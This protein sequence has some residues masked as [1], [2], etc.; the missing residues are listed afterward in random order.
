MPTAGLAVSPQRPRVQIRKKMKEHMIQHVALQ[1]KE[2]K[3]IFGE[4]AS[5]NDMIYGLK[6]W[7]HYQKNRSGM[8]KNK[9][10]NKVRESNG[11]SPQ[12]S[13]RRLG[14]KEVQHARST[15]TASVTPRKK[16]SITHKTGSLMIPK[17]RSTFFEYS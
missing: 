6:M 8:L 17:K 2:Y 5:Q 12:K 14:L 9:K 1:Q 10:E 11:E 13:G 16:F 7:R 15:Q 3:A 4:K